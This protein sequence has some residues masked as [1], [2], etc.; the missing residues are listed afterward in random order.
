MIEMIWEWESFAASRREQRKL[1][2]P[3][4]KGQGTRCVSD[5]RCLCPWSMS[6]NSECRC[7]RSMSMQIR[8]WFAE[9]NTAHDREL[10]GQKEHVAGAAELRSNQVV[11]RSR[12][13]CSRISFFPS[14]HGATCES[15]RKNEATNR[16]A[17]TPL[18]RLRWAFT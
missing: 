4:G 16:H 15:R 7:P 8:S 14:F 18:S 5:V 17:T 3:D 10:Q 2:W 13:G 11:S 12:S 1:V 6:M 9:P